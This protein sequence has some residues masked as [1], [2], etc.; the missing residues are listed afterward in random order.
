MRNSVNSEWYSIFPLFRISQWIV[1]RVGESSLFVYRKATIERNNEITRKL[2]ENIYF[3]TFPYSQTRSPRKRQS[4]PIIEKVFFEPTAFRGC[5]HT[6]SS[7]SN[8][9]ER[10]IYKSPIQGNSTRASDLF[11][12]ARVSLHELNWFLRWK[13]PNER[14]LLNRIWSRTTLDQVSIVLPHV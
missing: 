9:F 11:G 14:S 3:S 8:P 4:Y 13:F 6:S 5:F 10:T 1:A 12:L 2:F 7:F